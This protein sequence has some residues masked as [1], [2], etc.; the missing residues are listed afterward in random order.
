MFCTYVSKVVCVLLIVRTMLKREGREDGFRACVVL[1]RHTE[2]LRL[3][4]QCCCGVSWS[5]VTSCPPGLSLKLPGF[6]YTPCG[7]TMLEAH[8]PSTNTVML[9]CFQRKLT[10]TALTSSLLHRC[11][12]HPLLVLCHL[13]VENTL[14][15]DPKSH[16]AWHLEVQVNTV[17]DAVY[18]Y[19]LRGSK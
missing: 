11:L 8:I 14:L 9:T 17:Y 7:H 18:I 12:F 1:W 13:G 6:S 2:R 3:Y 19:L 4:S 5:T 15:T 10:C 16:L